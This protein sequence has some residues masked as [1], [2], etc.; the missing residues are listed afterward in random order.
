[1]KNKNGSVS[2]SVKVSISVICVCHPR[3]DLGNL[4]SRNKKLIRLLES[5]AILVAVISMPL[6]GLLG[7]SM[8]ADADL[9]ISPNVVLAQQ[10]IDPINLTAEDKVKKQDLEKVAMLELQAKTIDAYFT[11]RNMPLKGK[12]MKFALEAYNNDLDWRLLPAIAVRESTGGKHAC[13]SVPNSHLG[14]GGCKFGFKSTDYEI[15]VVSRSLGGR[16]KKTQHHY[17]ENSTTVK[18]LKKYNSVIPNYAN[19]V[20]SVMNAIGDKDLGLL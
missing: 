8:K 3:T 18:I 20:I 16:D 9:D 4:I 13:T 7:P 10:N 15:E 14:Y 17:P 2:T 19:E 1:M 11:A 6:G 5:F 12:G